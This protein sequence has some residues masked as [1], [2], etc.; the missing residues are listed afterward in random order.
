M[1]F[2]SY[3][4]VDINGFKGPNKWGRDQFAFESGILPYG[5]KLYADRY[6]DPNYYWRNNNYCTTENV[7]KGEWFAKFCTGRVLEEDAMNY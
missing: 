2:T 3:E 5:S 6:N 7:N 4:G 1:I